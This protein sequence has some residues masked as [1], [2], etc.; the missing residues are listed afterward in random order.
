M[1]RPLSII[2]ILVLLMVGWG[3]IR[4]PG[5]QGRERPTVAVQ[6]G[7]LVHV[8]RE[9]STLFSRDPVLVKNKYTATLKWVIEEGTWVEAGEKLFVVSADQLEEEVAQERQELIA[10]RQEL[11][12][13]KLKRQHA[14]DVGRLALDAAGRAYE[15]ATIRYRVLTSTPKGGLELIRIHEAL[16]PLE[17]KARRVRA[18]FEVAQDDYLEAQDEY[19]EAQDRFEASKTRYLRAQ[20]R[21]DELRVQTDLDPD[22]MQPEDRRKYDE[23]RTELTQTESEMAQ[24]EGLLPDLRKAMLEKRAGTEKL[25]GPLRRLEERLEQSDAETEELYVALEI[26]KRGLE[27]AYLQLD[28]EAAQLRLDQARAELDDGKATFA[29]GAIS[30]AAL[31]S[32]QGTH[33]TASNA[34]QIVRQKLKIASRPPADEEL[35]E[36]RTL[37]AKAKADADNAEEKYEHGL[38]MQDAEIALLETKIQK[39]QHKTDLSAF[40]FI[41]IIEANIAGAERELELIDPEDTER[42]A[43]LIKEV[44]KLKRRLAQA[45]ADPPHIYK[46]PASGIVRLKEQWGQRSIRPGDE[47]I[48]E[49][50]AVMIYPPDKLEVFSQV[51]EVNVRYVARGMPARVLVPSLKD[52][53]FTASVFQVAAVA[54]D[55]FD[56][57]FAWFEQRSFADVTQFDVRLRLNDMHP[58]LRQG[59][60]VVVELEADRR[61]DVLWLPAGAVRSTGDRCS[62]ITSGMDGGHVERTVV[63][64]FFSDDTFIVV[65]GLQEGDQVFIERKV[66]T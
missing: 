58:D 54:K 9:A 5:K 49:D 11:R 12:L 34:L 51:N 28:E 61:D 38:A 8:L 25:K 29:S 6:R 19:L 65:D 59:M 3:S 10:F 21:A 35:E 26:E 66:G 52:Q 15:L 30:K 43:E 23:A 20:A 16:Q 42:R 53:V 13:A 24:E 45:I 1:K 31:D 37:L 55:K 4:K 36:A 40:N 33:A 50:T 41:D 2:A 46:A 27:K 32:L 14:E 48:I 39:L 60:T 44:P 7:D 18:E 63:G 62:V 57:K 56:R 17:K 47:L 64:E 22:N